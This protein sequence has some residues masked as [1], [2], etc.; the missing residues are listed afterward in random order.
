[1]RRLRGDGL[2]SV[3]RRHLQSDGDGVLHTAR[4]GPGIVRRRSRQDDDDEGIGGRQEAEA[5]VGGVHA[6]GTDSPARLR[7]VVAT[8]LGEGQ[9]TLPGVSDEDAI[10]HRGR[11]HPAGRLGG[12]CHVRELDTAQ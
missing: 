10:A 2:G 4:H 3:Y 1:M 8:A 6:A 9:S 5:V 7:D 12:V 11:I